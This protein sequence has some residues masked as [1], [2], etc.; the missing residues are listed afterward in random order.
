MNNQKKLSHKQLIEDAVKVIGL[1]KNASDYVKYVRER[2]GVQTSSSS[3]VKAIGS[4]WTRDNT[5]KKLALK[6]AKDLL[7]ECFNDL[8]NAR[9]I[10]SEALYNN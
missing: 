7:K 1:H 10:L 9:Y 3:V 6:I 5:N 2:H 4:K 8:S